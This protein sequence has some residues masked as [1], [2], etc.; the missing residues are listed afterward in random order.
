M[1]ELYTFIFDAANFKVQ[2][3]RLVTSTCQLPMIHCKW[4][5][6]A[7]SHWCRNIPC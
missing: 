4:S 2:Y 3:S 6:I 1:A 5:Y 7:E